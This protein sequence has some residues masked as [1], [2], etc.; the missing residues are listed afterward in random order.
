MKN[1]ILF[2]A[3]LLLSNQIIAQQKPLPYFPTYQKWE[4]K[5]PAELGLNP[6]KIQEAIAFSQANESKNPRSMEQSHY[7]SFGKEPFGNAVGPFADRGDQTGLIIY[8][9]YIVAPWG[10]PSRCD[11]TPSVTKSF[12]STVV[13][14][15]VDKGLIKNVNDSVFSYVPPIELYGQAVNRSAE[16]FGKPELLR[17]FETPHNKTITWET[18]LR[19]TSDWEGTLW[20]KPDW[21]DRPDKD[22][23]TWLTRPRNVP[24]SVYEYNDV[25]VNALALATMGVWRKPLPQVLKE[26]IMD[27]IGA[28]N[29]WR[30]TGYRNSWIVLDGQP[31]Q[32]V[33][34]GGHWGGGMFI[35]AYD[36]ARFGLLT[37]HKGNWNGKQLLSEQWVK[38]AT[39]PTT[40]Q[41]TYGYMNWFLNTDQKPL[42]SASANVFYHVGNGTNI[43]YVDPEHDLVMVTRWIET[44]ALDGIVKRLLEAFTPSIPDTELY[45]TDLNLNNGQIP[46]GKPMN[47]T[48]R[49]GY[50][51][52][53]SFTSD[54]K[55]I[56]Y[57]QQENNQTDIWTYDITKQ[58]NTILTQTP[59]SEYSATVMPDGKHFSAIRV[60]ADQTQRLWQFDLNN[61]KNPKLVLKNLKPVGYHRWFGSDSLLLFVLGEPNTLQL[62]QVSTEKSQVI[63]TNIGRSLHLI[64]NEKAMSFIHK[65]SAKTWN[66]ERLDMNTL[67]TTKLIETLEGSED[68]V[69]TS[70]GTLLMAS[71]AKLYKWNQKVDKTWQ[72]VADYTDLGIKKITRLAINPRNNRL[73][74]VAG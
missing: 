10:E 25:R 70:D 19:Q 60:E 58:K 28:S 27:P 46:I 66:V 37:L 67:Q 62:A 31:V 50:D 45:L 2:I 5:K 59:E 73:V 26:Y 63:T 68:C 57:T 1:L 51:N 39:T 14:L 16:D 15:A 33:S 72:L 71:G 9:G 64:P 56:L 29:T 32:S 18:M 54:G 34:G 52:Q 20:G 36:M 30:W 13:G 21:A 47:I 61:G 38:Q 12:L 53:P 42:P 43:I 74:F 24:G 40:A 48:K 3:I 23:N 41:P 35:N 55:K 65:I 11:I 6:T 44:N 49:K 7:Q 8:K 17:P 22:V 69:W 4:T